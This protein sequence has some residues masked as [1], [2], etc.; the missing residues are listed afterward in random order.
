MAPLAGV[1]PGPQRSRAGGGGPAAGSLHARALRANR[2]EPRLLAA[3]APERAGGRHQPRGRP[4]VQRAVRAGGRVPAAR[5]SAR[6]IRTPASAPKRGGTK[7]RSAA[8]CC[9]RPSARRCSIASPTPPSSIRQTLVDFTFAD[10]QTDR[11]QALF[12][13]DTIRLGNL[14]ASAGLRWDRYDFVVEDSAFSPR[15]GVAVV[16]ARA[17]ISSCAPPT[18]GRFRRRP[19]RTCCSPARPRWIR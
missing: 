10:R 4:L 3:S 18:T 1:V 7:S 14:T 8:T 11:E 17:P 12:A 2:L 6:R 13:Q 19:W 16:L 5:L 15:L 9:T